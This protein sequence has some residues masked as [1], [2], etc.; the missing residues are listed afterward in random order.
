[1]EAVHKEYERSVDSHWWFRARRRI[2][3]AVLEAHVPLPERAT[4]VE[5]GPGWGVNVPLLGPRGRLI[6]VD[7]SL[8]SLESCLSR[9]ADLAVLGDGATPPLAPDSVDL[10][11]ALDVLE[12]LDDDDGALRSW[13]AALRDDGHLLLSVPAL[14]ILWGRQDVLSE[15][16]RRYTRAT[17]QRRLAAA[18]LEVQRLSYF[19]SVLF[20]PILAVRL[21]MRPLLRWTGRSQS[22]DL[23]VRAPLG[24][25]GLLYG[26]FAA[27]APWL[28]RHD[29]PLGV[30]LL[31]VARRA[32]PA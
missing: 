16:R 9:G 18:G 14:P 30:S 3:D 19:N 27:E 24:L 17:L 5:L 13:C 29:L 22:S 10:L 6:V 1:M 4:I 2:F 21:A 32:R 25:D 31:C 20:L 11:C 23:S 28:A 15:H 8:P 12:H 26:A 7:A